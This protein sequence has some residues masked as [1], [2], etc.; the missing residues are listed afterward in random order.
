MI[1][2]RLITEHDFGLNIDN[3]I[4][5]FLTERSLLEYL[6]ECGRQMGMSM[7]QMRE[8][9]LFSINTIEVEDGIYNDKHITLK[10]NFFD[11]ILLEHPSFTQEERELII[12]SLI[13]LTTDWSKLL[14][15]QDD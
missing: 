13:N 5:V 1:L 9:D 3:N 10:I 4:G 2:Y 7:E 14:I 8:S 6:E 11:Q 12:M 15:K